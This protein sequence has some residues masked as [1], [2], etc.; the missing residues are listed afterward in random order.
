MSRRKISITYSKCPRCNTTTAG[1]SKPIHGSKTMHKKY[2][3]LCE[4][5][6]TNEER[7]EILNDQAKGILSKAGE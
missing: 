6:A 1:L 4:S 5:C 7:K 3:G 2:K